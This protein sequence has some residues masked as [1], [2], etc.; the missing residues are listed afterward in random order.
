VA[1]KWDLRSFFLCMAVSDAIKKRGHLDDYKKVAWKYGKAKE[2]VE[3]A[4]AGLSLLGESVRK[5]RK[6]KKQTKE[7]KKVAPAKAT[8]RVS[9]TKNSFFL[10]LEY[11]G[12]EVT[13]LG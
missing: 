11:R 4:R 13:H 6:E 8:F 3:S 9:L 10:V 2:A 12:S 1:R 7:G 5:S